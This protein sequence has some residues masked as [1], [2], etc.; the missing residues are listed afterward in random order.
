M[1]LH[2]VIVYVTIILLIAVHCVCVLYILVSNLI[3]CVL[4]LASKEEQPCQLLKAKIQIKSNQHKFQ[5]SSPNLPVSPIL[6]YIL[7]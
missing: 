6:L 1:Y 4:H 7:E 3:A 2:P 5:W